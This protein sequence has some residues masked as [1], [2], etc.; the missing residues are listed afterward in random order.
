VPIDP[1][2]LTARRPPDTTTVELRFRPSCP[3][4]YAAVAILCGEHDLASNAELEAVL[5][6][7][8]GNLLIDLSRCEFIDSTV[9]GALIRKSEDLAREGH[10]LDLVVTSA[11]IQ[12]RRVLDVVGMSSLMTILPELPTAPPHVGLTDETAA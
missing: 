12:V 8:D 4:G 10:R 6:P 11:N 3:D 7:I 1:T 5:A 2:H 9:I